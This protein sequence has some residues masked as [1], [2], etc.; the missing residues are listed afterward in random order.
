MG[1][2]FGL[3]TVNCDDRCGDDDSSCQ[4]SCFQEIVQDQPDSLRIYCGVVL[5]FIAPLC[6]LLL[7]YHAY[8]FPIKGL[9]LRKLYHTIM[10]EQGDRSY[11]EDVCSERTQSNIVSRTEAQ[12]AK[13]KV[14]ILADDVHSFLNPDLQNQL[15]STIQCVN[16]RPDPKSCAVIIETLDDISTLRNAATSDTTSKTREEDNSQS[17]EVVVQHPEPSADGKTVNAAA[18]SMAA[19]VGD[20]NQTL[21][22]DASQ[23]AHEGSDMPAPRKEEPA[24]QDT[25]DVPALQGEEATDQEASDVRPLGGKEARAQQASDVPG[26]AFPDTLVEDSRDHTSGGSWCCRT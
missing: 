12:A 22:P 25:S 17:F 13:S 15:D 23:K 21:E 3:K 5:G 18:I 26:H 7:S 4:D 16:K 20:G 24:T 2:V 9:R 19:E 6:E 11:L 1:S 10:E 8:N 14:V